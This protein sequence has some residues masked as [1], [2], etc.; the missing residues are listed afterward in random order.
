MSEK[1]MKKNE[2]AKASKRRTSR[3]QNGHFTQKML[4][5]SGTV[6]VTTIISTMTSNNEYHA[7]INH[8]SI[9]N[10]NVN[11]FR[12]QEPSSGTSSMMTGPSYDQFFSQMYL[13]EIPSA[14]TITG[15]APS[16]SNLHCHSRMSPHKYYLIEKPANVENYCGCNELFSLHYCQPS[17][18]VIV[19]HI[20]R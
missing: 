12:N 5:Q 8:A 13:L 3:T 9:L 10:I 7:C 18:N 14:H 19:K 17:V 1:S 11:I 6:R 16:T 4:L 15:N 2:I 20:D